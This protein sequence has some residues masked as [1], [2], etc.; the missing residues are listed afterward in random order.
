MKQHTKHIVAAILAGLSMLG[1]VHV[2]GVFLGFT[3]KLNIITVSIATF[4]GA[5]GVALLL[6]LAKILML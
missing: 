3:I 6:L 1:V 4:F 2:L 5:P